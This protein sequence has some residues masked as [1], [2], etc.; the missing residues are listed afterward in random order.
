MVIT[1]HREWEFSSGTVKIFFTLIQFSSFFIKLSAEQ[2]GHFWQLTDLHWDQ[3][4]STDGDP[5]SMCHANEEHKLLS[6]AKSDS[7]DYISA[8]QYG[9]YSCDAPWDLI[10]FSIRGMAENSAAPNFIIWTGDNTPHVKDPSPDWSV[11]FS[12]L[13]NVSN[14][15][16]KN[17]P[18]T[19]LIPVLG[20]HDVFPEDLY[21]A[22]AEAFY[23]AYLTDGGWNELLDK[24]AQESFG[25]CGFYS[26][27]VTPELKVVILNTNLYNEPNNLTR[28]QD[29]PCGQLK[30]FELQ[31]EEAQ[32]KK[33]KVLIAAH[34]PPGYFERWIGPPFFNP[35]QND[36]Y[37]Q[38]IQIYGDVILTQVYGHTHTDSFRIIANNQSQ[39]KSVAFVSPSVTPW[40]HTGGVN[41]SLR[42][43]SYDSDG[44]KDYWQYYF[45]LTG[46]AVKTQATPQWQL[47]YQATVAYGVKDLSPANMLS[48][49]RD[50]L[51]DPKVFERY[52]FFNTVGH[53]FQDCD[54]AC[55]RD[56][57]CTISHLMVNDMKS[58]LDGKHVLFRNDPTMTDHFL[59]IA[60]R[61]KV[62]ENGSL[63]L[64]LFLS[65]LALIC[66]VIATSIFVLRR[67][68]VY[69]SR[70][71]ASQEP[72]SPR[73]R[74]S[75]YSPIISQDENA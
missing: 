36:R 16:R 69:N 59:K 21:P 55:I 18:N 11:I 35:G 20:N 61:A 1:W 32:S 67:R 10:E 15:I 19:T 53:V 65:A 14:A 56:H 4:Y 27:N 72:L 24:Q 42:L 43:Y 31:L 46:M 40:L 25:K 41:P 9:M 62:A 60:Q 58:C 22:E 73:P 54:A 45:N 6:S 23:H 2:P 33:S 12:S 52:Y 63:I 26:L 64:T 5:G 13:R 51:S 39:V 75:D 8:G 29:D 57:I 74:Q 3:R 30:W 47:L 38:L 50:M 7:S 44:I 66:I 49:Y 48:I 28:N 71:R 34:I 37:V 70:V 68:R 17:F